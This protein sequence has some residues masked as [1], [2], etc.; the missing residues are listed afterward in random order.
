M[1]PNLLL[2]HW[3]IRSVAVFA[4]LAAVITLYR[5]LW[6]LYE[7]GWR[8]YLREMFRI[9]PETWRVI[10]VLILIAVAFLLAYTCPLG[11]GW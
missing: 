3:L 2:S 6:F 8:I 10:A 5:H 11:L 9:E 7:A 4:V 1:E